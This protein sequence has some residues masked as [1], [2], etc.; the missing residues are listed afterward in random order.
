MKAGKLRHLVQF[1]RPGTTQDE[2]GQ[3]VPG[4]VDAFKEWAEISPLS[5]GELIS[6]Q[7]VQSK[8]TARMRLRY[9]PGFSTT[10]R[11][12]YRDTIYNIEAVIPDPKSGI[13]WVTLL[14]SS[15]LNAG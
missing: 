12:V 11:G 1:Q 13:E 2:I 5:G 14:C 8:A 9:R 15:G 4:W 10:M 3:P 7:A 6:A